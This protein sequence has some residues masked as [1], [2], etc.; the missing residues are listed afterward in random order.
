ML[1]INYMHLCAFILVPS[2][3]IEN[4]EYMKFDQLGIMHPILKALGDKDYVR[5]TP[6]QEKAIPILLNRR[7][8]MGCAQTGT[9]KTAAFAI[10]IIQLI[11]EREAKKNRTSDIALFDR[12]AYP[13]T[14]YT[15][16]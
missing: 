16:R 14:R 7:D 2:F 15:D 4:V 11:E 5:P 8:L 10:P 3:G 13:G 6:I 9:G 1:V 12:H